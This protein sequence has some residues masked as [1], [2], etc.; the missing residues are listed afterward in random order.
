MSALIAY[1]ARW[2]TFVGIIK[3]GPPTLLEQRVTSVLQ[4][5]AD[6]SAGV[7]KNSL[8]VKAC[9]RPLGLANRDEIAADPG[10]SSKN[11]RRRACSLANPA[12][13]RITKGY[14]SWS[15]TW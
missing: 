6:L 14:R 11:T 8:V 4:D 3:S 9:D 12:S 15:P 10:P 2:E 13:T 7:V 5:I 1:A